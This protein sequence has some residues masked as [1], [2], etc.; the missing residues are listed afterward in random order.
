MVCL[1]L[2]RR[3][4][5]DAVYCSFVSWISSPSIFKL[6]ATGSWWSGVLFLFRLVSSASH[7]YV[8]KVDN[9]ALGRRAGVLSEQRR[10]TGFEKHILWFG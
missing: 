5:H 10:N 9:L 2:L 6:V 7:M 8:L 1:V 3:R 4:A